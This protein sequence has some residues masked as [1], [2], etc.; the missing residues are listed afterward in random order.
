MT[1]VKLEIDYR[2]IFGQKVVDFMSGLDLGIDDMAR[3]YMALAMV[4]AMALAM[5][6]DVE[7]VKTFFT[8]NALA[9]KELGK[10]FI[11]I[12]ISPEYCDIIKER[13]GCE[14]I[15]QLIN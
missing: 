13:I 1:S 5:A 10:E 6:M 8:T 11:G 2:T 15:K 9:A 7:T 14:I 12:E 3:T 4:L